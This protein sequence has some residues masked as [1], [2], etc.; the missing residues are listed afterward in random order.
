M[1][2]SDQEFEHLS[3]LALPV[4]GKH[5]NDLALCPGGIGHRAKHIHEGANADFLSNRSRKAHGR[6]VGLSK[7]KPTPIS[8]MQVA[9]CFGVKESETPAASR[10]SALPLKLVIFR[11]PCLATLA[12]ALA[13]TKAAA[14]EMLKSLLPLPPVP[15][16][17]TKVSL[18]R[19]PLSTARAW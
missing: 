6:V 2:C 12:P 4:S 17:S 9:T 19:V 15:Q 16:V 14:V 3:Y 11:L 1:A 13:A 18:L 5:P 10:T 8:S 7:L